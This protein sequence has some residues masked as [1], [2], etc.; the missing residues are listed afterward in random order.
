VGKVLGLGLL[1]S[2]TGMGARGGIGSK[3]R[4]EL[5]LRNKPNQTLDWNRRKSF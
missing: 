5:K 3:V 2:T 4:L 1:F